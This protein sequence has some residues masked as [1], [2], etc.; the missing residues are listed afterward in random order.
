MTAAP[1]SQRNLAFV[2][3]LISQTPST[4]IYVGIAAALATIPGV[5]IPLLMRVFV[6]QYLVADET[7]WVAPVVIGMLAAVVVIATVTLLQYRTLS[8]L[9]VR[10]SASESTRF[11]WRL[12]RLPVSTIERFG[13][14]DL[15]ARAGALQRYAFLTGLLVPMAMANI[16]MI[17]VYTIAVIALDWKLGVVGIVVV[18]CSML[19]S[20]LLLRRRRA[21]QSRADA[22]MIA[23][24]ASTTGSVASIETI[25]AAGWE[26]WVFDRWSQRRSET[27]EAWSVLS[28][29]GQRLGLVSPL[30]YTFGLGLILAVGAV[31]VFWGS[32]SLG[33]LVAAQTLLLA[34]LVPAGQLVWIGVLIESAASIDRQADA[35]AA[36]NL[37]PEVTSTG[38]GSV[39]R[40]G[41]IELE[42]RGVTFGYES[43]EA[44][45][46]TGLDIRVPSG[47]W[48]AVVGSSGSGKSTLSRLAVGELQPWAGEVVIDGRPRLDLLRHERALRVGYVPQNP[49]LMPGTIADNITMFDASVPVE[50]IRRALA[51]ACILDAIEARAG[52]LS[53]RVSSTGHGFSGGELQ[54]LAIARA[55]VRDPGL[56]ILDEATSALD[57]VTE[58]EVIRVLRDRSCT[59][60]VV[61]H[62]LSS[63]R[64]ADHIIVM[65]QGAIVQQGSFDEVRVGGRFAELAH[66]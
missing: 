57:P 44:P 9:S 46:M 47:T 27:S 29:D 25:K 16:V 31:L 37:D 51:D 12:L 14:G 28:M 43:G 64:D 54:R 50:E 3:E 6:D 49:I 23:L 38:S 62:R 26:P 32:L 66:G 65:E 2:R 33:T 39:R 40:T 13:T 34:I 20:T 21:L 59:C 19:V 55:L 5:V 41:A 8:R 36:L 61:A 7:Q 58:L 35:V 42:L 18:S 52:G 45:L 22:T 63:V 11:V 17:T 15:S 10:M 24:T 60:L 1:G 4:Y 30:A 56:L 53:E 48:L